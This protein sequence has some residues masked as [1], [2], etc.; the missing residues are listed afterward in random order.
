[1]ANINYNY[2]N[3]EDKDRSHEGLERPMVCQTI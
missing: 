1:M 3:N 2:N